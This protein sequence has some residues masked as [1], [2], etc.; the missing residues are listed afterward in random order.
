MA[1]LAWVMMGVAIWHFTIF[2]PDRFWGGIVG[3]FI[4][5][6]AGSIIFGFV[7]HGLSVPARDDT[8]IVTALEGVPGAMLGM[9]VIWFIGVRN[10]SEQE[11]A[12]AFGRRT[13]G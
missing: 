9:A 5:A 4:G 3:A 10:E 7:I 8:T 12:D 11:R 6:F 1:V 13:A 2:L